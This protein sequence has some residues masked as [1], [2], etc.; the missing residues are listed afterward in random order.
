MTGKAGLI[1]WCTSEAESPDGADMTRNDYD[2]ATTQEIIDRVGEHT[3]LPLAI[4]TAR[5]AITESA[6]RLTWIDAGETWARVC[7]ATPGVTYPT[8]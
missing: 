3:A 7:R 1:N 4:D 2:D 5:R 6:G 8:L